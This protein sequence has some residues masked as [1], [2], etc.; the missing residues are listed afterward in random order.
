MLIHLTLH[1][2][3]DF[4]EEGAGLS[5]ALLQE[6]GEVVGG[7][8][9]CAGD[10]E[11]GGH[12][13]PV[14]C[15]LVDV[16]EAGG[17]FAGFAGVEAGEFHVEDVVGAVGEDQRGDVEAFP[18]LGPEALVGVGCAAVAEQGQHWPVGAGQACAGGDRA[19]LADGA[20]GEAEPAIG[21]GVLAEGVGGV[22]AAGVGADDDVFG[23]GRGDRLDDRSH[24]DLAFR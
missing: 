10:A 7:G 15:W 5:V 23:H 17:D 18:G 19:A 21:C 3:V 8:G 2:A 6:F 14:D 4:D 1:L 13:N 16:E 24:S 12:L 11:A 20:A 22:A 9:C